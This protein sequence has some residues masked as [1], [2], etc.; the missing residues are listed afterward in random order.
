MIRNV[1]R[2]MFRSTSSPF[3]VCSLLALIHILAWTWDEKRNM[4]V[5]FPLIHFLKQALKYFLYTHLIP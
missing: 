2:C 4:S 1:W 5:L 3:N